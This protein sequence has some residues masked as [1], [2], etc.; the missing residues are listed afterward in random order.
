MSKPS[1]KEL[2]QS[3]GNTE[4]TAK[5]VAAYLTQHPNFFQQHTELLNSLHIPHQATLDA[6]GATQTVSLIERQVKSLR[7]ENK[8]LQLQLNKLIGNAQIN[9]A[10]FEKARKLVLKL[11]AITS[12]TPLKQIVEQAM[13]DDFDSDYCHMWYVTEQPAN[14]AKGQKELRLITEKVGRLTAKNKVFCGILKEPECEFLFGDNADKVGSAAVL[15]LF[16]DKRLIAILA[17][18]NQD[19]AYYRNNMS[20]DLLNHVGQVIAQIIARFPLSNSQ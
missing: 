20:T 1:N 6:G 8:Q 2:E 15:P 10:L 9:D 16:S 5:G 18:A 19:E 13:N 17:I 7:E 14:E 11:I 3:K 4:T 12:L